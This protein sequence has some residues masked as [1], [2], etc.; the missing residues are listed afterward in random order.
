MI[1]YYTYPHYFDPALHYLD[2][3][4][5]SYNIILFL[6]LHPS[7]LQ[8][9]MFDLSDFQ[10]KPG[11]Y[12]GF[13]FLNEFDLPIQKILR[14]LEAFYIIYFPR[15]FDLNTLK[16]YKRIRLFLRRNDINII[17]FDDFS[18]R[19][20]ILLY[21]LRN[22]YFIGNVHD[23]FQH[24]GEELFLYKILKRV[25]YKKLDKIFIF[26]KF[27]LLNFIRK[28]RLHEPNV[29]STQLGYY[30]LY[31]EYIIEKSSLT[32][33]ILFFGRLSLYKGI[34]VFLEASQEVLKQFPDMRIIIAGKS[35]YGYSLPKIEDKR[36]MCLNYHISNQLL[37]NLIY[38]SSIIVLPYKDSTQSGALLTAL[39]FGKPTVSSNV[40]S[41]PE[42]INSG[43][44]GLVFNVGSS[45]DLADKIKLLLVNRELYNDINANILKSTDTWGNFISNATR[46]YEEINEKKV[47]KRLVKN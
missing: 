3:I 25:I 45:S 6:E 32:N 26:N 36:I 18:P 40:G 43:V 20:I 8:T 24:S 12:N 27:S 9:A 35:F 19:S 38:N 21:I 28:Y 23:T 2:N 10:H 29:I 16:N 46:I 7:N 22:I 5:S 37:A 1:I 14:K 34:D 42:Y 15:K 17:H 47:F 33:Y 41:F 30:Y 31:K 44:N 11:F 4:S 39:A 13:D